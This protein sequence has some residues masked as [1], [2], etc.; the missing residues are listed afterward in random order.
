M[1][2]ASMKTE[3]YGYLD[4][5]IYCDAIVGR[6][7]CGFEVTGIK[8]TI[9]GSKWATAQVIGCRISKNGKRRSNPHPMTVPVHLGSTARMALDDLIEDLHKEFPA[10]IGAWE[11]LSTQYRSFATL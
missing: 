7:G 9:D 8:L 2:H 4:Q 5:S 6:L 11:E 3:V 1:Q 10:L